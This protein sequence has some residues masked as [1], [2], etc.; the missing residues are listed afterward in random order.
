MGRQF[1][2]FRHQHFH[3]LKGLACA[4]AGLALLAVASP[5]SADLLLALIA[6]PNPAQAGEEVTFSAVLQDAQAACSWE[7]AGLATVEGNPA[8]YTF[9]RAGTYLVVLSAAF[10]TESLQEGLVV[11]VRS[12][13]ASRQPTIR[14]LSRDP[15]GLVYPG[16]TVTFS[17]TADLLGQIEPTFI[18]LFG[19]GASQTGAEVSHAYS[20]G[21]TYAVRLFAA[22]PAGG[23]SERSLNV[24]V[25]G[26][27]AEG[28][29]ADAGPDQIVV[30]ESQ[31]FLVGCASVSTAGS[32]DYSWRQTAGPAV[33]LS[34]AGG[35][36]PFFIAPVQACDLTFELTVSHGSLG[37]SDQVQV[38]VR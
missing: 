13:G 4:L 30:P 19:D 8:S 32:L 37:D 38:S 9:E 20:E 17:V 35:S 24:V 16:Q 34:G 18:W 1:G 5:V 3:W 36:E 27:A 10:G 12:S 28:I 33:T 22:N 11:E 23:Q 26:P 25:S 15:T 14:T 31:V 7:V 2:K 21:G 6:S 29:L